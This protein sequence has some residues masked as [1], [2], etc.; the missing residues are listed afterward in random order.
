MTHD[1]RKKLRRDLSKKQ[2]GKCKYCG[3]RMIRPRPGEH[4]R[5]RHGTIDHKIPTSRGGPDTPENSVMSCFSCNQRKGDLTDTEF[6]NT[7][8]KAS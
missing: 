5:P 2:N 6:L 1:E 8:E 4:S 3:V 7:R